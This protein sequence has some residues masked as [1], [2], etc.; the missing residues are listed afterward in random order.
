MGCLSLCFEFKS[1]PRQT[2]QSIPIQGWSPAHCTYMRFLPGLVHEASNNLL[3]F[4]QILHVPSKEKQCVLWNH[5]KYGFGSHNKVIWNQMICWTWK[6]FLFVCI[7]RCPNKD[8]KSINI[9]TFQILFQHKFDFL[10][11]VCNHEHFIPLC[12]P[13]RSADIPGKDFHLL[14]CCV[15]SGKSAWK[16]LICSHEV[17]I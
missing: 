2:A 15:L 8:C 10:Q 14:F 12:L 16:S 5:K 13:M 17:M 7:L 9:L 4:S 11:E 1:F 3:A 6:V